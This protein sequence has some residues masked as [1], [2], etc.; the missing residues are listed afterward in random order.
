MAPAGLEISRADLVLWLQAPGVDDEVSVPHTEAPIW[1]IDSKS[2]LPTYSA[3]GVI[4]ASRNDQTS[5]EKLLAKIAVIASEATNPG[6]QLLVSHERDRTALVAALLEL[7]LVR[8]QLDT[9]EIAA[10]GLRQ[11]SDAL[12]RLIG[13]VDAEQVLD[14]LFSSFCIGK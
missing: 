5:I 14:R 12:G 3:R 13:S 1:R 6:E 2:D 9:P 8:D 10:E 4:S 11:A 7:G